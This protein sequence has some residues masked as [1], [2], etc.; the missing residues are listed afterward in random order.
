MPYAPTSNA[1]SPAV[2]RRD[3][4]PAPMFLRGSGLF[5]FCCFALP[6]LAIHYPALLSL[7]VLPVGRGRWG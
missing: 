5:I 3:V 2:E 7:Y 4:T 6:L 1:H